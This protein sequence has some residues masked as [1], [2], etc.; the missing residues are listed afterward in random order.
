MKSNESITVKNDGEYWIGVCGNSTMD[1]GFN[2]C[3]NNGVYNEPLNIITLIYIPVLNVDVFID[4]DI[5]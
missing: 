1:D 4:Q 2:T 5:Y 3:D